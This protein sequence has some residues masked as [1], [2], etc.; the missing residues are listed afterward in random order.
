MCL[1]STQFHAL[2]VGGQ[3]MIPQPQLPEL[4]A[5][6]AEFRAQVLLCRGRLGGELVEICAGL[7][8]RPHELLDDIRRRIEA[9]LLVG[10][11]GE[12]GNG[13]RRRIPGY[14]MGG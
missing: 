4:L 14:A 9:S 10:P 2:K 13:S 5:D 11:D 7:L 12:R 1:M 6:A 3:L 8:E